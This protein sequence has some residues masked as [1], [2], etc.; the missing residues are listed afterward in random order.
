MEIFTTV[1]SKFHAICDMTIGTMKPV[2]KLGPE[3]GRKADTHGTVNS[4]TAGKI[5][6]KLIE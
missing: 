1:L 6:L 2:K 3:P 4:G 5:V